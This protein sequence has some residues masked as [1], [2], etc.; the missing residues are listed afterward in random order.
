[1]KSR[2]G[3]RLATI[4]LAIVML[5]VVAACGENGGD[6]V[7]D[8]YQKKVTFQVVNGT[9][10]DDLS[11]IHIFPLLPGPEPPAP[12]SRCRTAY[13]QFTL[14]VCCAARAIRG[15]IPS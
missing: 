5:L 12:L 14:S 1:M 9:W 3:T 7:P 4:L 6:G 8:K 15:F 10:E 13:R 2:K 11:L